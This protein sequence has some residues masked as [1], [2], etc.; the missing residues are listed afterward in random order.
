M[1]T[2]EREINVWPGGELVS[3][4]EHLVWKA[5]EFAQDD[6]STLPPEQRVTYLTACAERIAAIVPVEAAERWLENPQELTEAQLAYDRIYRG[7]TSP[8][9]QQKQ[10]MA[11]VVRRYRERPDL[12]PREVVTTYVRGHVEHRT[13]SGRLLA[14]AE[15]EALKAEERERYPLRT[16]TGKTITEAQIERWS[17]E[18]EQGYE[19]VKPATVHKIAQ[20]IERLLN[21]GI[22]SETELGIPVPVA[23]AGERAIA[24][25]EGWLRS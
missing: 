15:I 5:A 19:V 11:D 13:K 9:E 18:A 22:I 24:D 23:M 12:L 1:T 4:V 17:A 6:T 20:V 2:P 8:S 16:A 7:E 14:D 21:K 3:D 10:A 25:I